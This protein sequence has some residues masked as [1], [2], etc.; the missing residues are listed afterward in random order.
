MFYLINMPHYSIHRPCLALA[1]F[2]ALFK[3]ENLPSRVLDLNFLLADRIGQ[4]RHN[5]FESRMRLTELVSTLWG[6]YA[7]GSSF[8]AVTEKWLQRCESHFKRVPDPGIG[9]AWMLK[10]RD[11]HIPRFLSDCLDRLFG[12]PPPAV[13]GFS[14]YLFS[15]ALPALALG[16]LIRER[17]PEIKLVYGGPMFHGEMGKEYIQKIDWIDAVSTG[18]ADDV[19]VRLFCDLSEGKDPQGLQGIVYRDRTGAVQHGPAYRPVSREVFAALP[20]PDFDDFFESAAQTGIGADP[21]WRENVALFLEG[22]RGCYWGCKSQCAFCGVNGCSMVYRSKPGKQVY[23]TIAA[24]IEKHHVFGFLIGDTA[25]CHEHYDSLLPRLVRG[26]FQKQLRFFGQV[27]VDISRQQ[28]ASLANAGFG[29][30]QVGIENLSTRILQLL[31]KG[32]R[33]IQNVYL[34]KL[35]RQYGIRPLWSFLNRIPGERLEYYRES[36]ALIPMIVHLQP[37]NFGSAVSVE[38]HRFS[39]YFTE[40]TKIRNMR[41]KAWY[42]YQYPVDQIDLSR[43]AYSFDA[44]WLDTLDAGDYEQVNACLAAWHRAWETGSQV[45]ALVV[46]SRQDNGSVE[47]ED[48]RVK[49]DP[50]RWI[51]GPEQAAVLAALDDPGSLDRVMRELAK[52]AFS[53][54][55]RTEVEGLLRDLMEVDSGIDLLVNDCSNDTKHLQIMK[56][57]MNPFLRYFRSVENGKAVWQA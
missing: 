15:Q 52:G 9:I 51:L 31:R 57:N 6:P 30:L 38:L 55:L 2:K 35:C 29:Y 20:D 7:W 36:A 11:I 27:R 13:I 56:K 46:R 47:I 1:L 19:I 41:P 39:P 37:P 4:A 49:G 22:S 32:T 21:Q 12:G 53:A 50:R 34:L 54:L 40:K 5:Y 18:E 24:C 23:K 3:R 10:F 45:P 16:R 33:A 25:M 17:R 14:C 48:T 43:V 26:P 28:V 42:A 8:R 44:E